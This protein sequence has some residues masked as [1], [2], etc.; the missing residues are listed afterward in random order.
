VRFLSNQPI[1]KYLDKGRKWWIHE[2]E[3]VLGEAIII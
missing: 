3:R 2:G 1:E